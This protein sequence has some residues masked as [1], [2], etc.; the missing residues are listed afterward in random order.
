MGLSRVL[1][2]G[3]LVAIGGSDKLLVSCTPSYLVKITIFIPIFCQK[4][5]LNMSEHPP[6]IIKWVSLATIYCSTMWWPPAASL[7]GLAFLAAFLALAGGEEE[8][9]DKINKL[10]K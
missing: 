6:G 5:W 1:H 7:G 3:P 4:P 10:W 2:W 8:I 9:K